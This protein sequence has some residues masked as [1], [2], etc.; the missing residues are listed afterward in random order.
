[1]LSLLPFLYRSRDAKGPALY[2]KE[3]VGLA[4]ASKE[5]LNIVNETPSVLRAPLPKR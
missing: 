5:P 1:V 3:R 4:I 2:K